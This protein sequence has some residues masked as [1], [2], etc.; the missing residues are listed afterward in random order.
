MHTAHAFKACALGF[1][2]ATS[3][4]AA[5][6]TRPSP[7]E[8]DLRERDWRNGAIVY[9]VIVDRFAPSAQLEAKRGLY[10]APKRLRPW[11]EPAW[12]LRSLM[13]WRPRSMR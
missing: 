11:S 6:T 1:A 2:L 10:P 7:S 9:Q 8:Y 3:A 4:L 12:R 5:P 13:S